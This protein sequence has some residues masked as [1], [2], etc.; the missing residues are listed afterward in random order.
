M[1]AGVI[2]C[3]WKNFTLE[4]RDRVWTCDDAAVAAYFN[5][6]TEEIFIHGGIPDPDEFIVQELQRSMAIE[7][8]YADPPTDELPHDGTD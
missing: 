5:D 2:R 3:R 1:K 6:R 4:L 7:V 8:V